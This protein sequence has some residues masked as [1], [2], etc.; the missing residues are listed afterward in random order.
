MSSTNN[1]CALVVVP[2]AADQAYVADA[3]SHTDQ[4]GTHKWVALKGARAGPA[5]ALKPTQQLIKQVPRVLLQVVLCKPKVR[6]SS[7]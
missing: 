1:I 4:S 3:G 6:H 5:N 2:A 7:R